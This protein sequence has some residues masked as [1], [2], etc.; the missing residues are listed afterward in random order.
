[1][2]PVSIE[3]LPSPVRSSTTK[4]RITLGFRKVRFPLIYPPKFAP[5]RL[6]YSTNPTIKRGRHE[7]LQSWGQAIV[8]KYQRGKKIEHQVCSDELS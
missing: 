2:L 3:P 5:I 6:M 7:F 1:M 8:I 4:I